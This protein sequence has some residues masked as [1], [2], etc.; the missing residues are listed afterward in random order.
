MIFTWGL[1]SALQ[2]TAT[3]FAGL[4]AAR[5]FVGFAEAGFGTG[6]ALYLGE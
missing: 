5:F 3:N 1:A 6:I 4:M 2:A